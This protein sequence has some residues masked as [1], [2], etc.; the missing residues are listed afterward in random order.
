MASLQETLKVKDDTLNAVHPLMERFQKCI[1][2]S[3]LKLSTRFAAL[4]THI[5]LHV[6]IKGTCEMWA[7]CF[8]RA[9][10]DEKGHLLLVPGSDEQNVVINDETEAVLVDVVQLMDAPEDVVSALVWFQPIDLFYRLWPDAL[11]LS[12]FFGMVS[13][14]VTRDGKFYAPTWRGATGPDYGEMICEVVESTSQVV[15]HIASDRHSIKGKHW[16][17]SVVLSALSKIRIRLKYGDVLVTVPMGKEFP[18]EI[19]EVKFGPFN[20][21][22]DQNNSV[23]GR[24]WHTF[25]SD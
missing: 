23:V 25:P 10:T 24:K 8:E 6:R 13:S 12:S 4:E 3:N 22:P 16:N 11:Y 2:L 7:V 9:W 14:F 15:D 19:T 20:F 21:Y 17:R 1:G 5:I 18:I